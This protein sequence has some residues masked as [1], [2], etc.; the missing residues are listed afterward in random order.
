MRTH[1]LLRF[2]VVFLL[3][4]AC[5]AAQE[6]PTPEK[7]LGFRVGTDKKLASW[8]QVVEYMRM[9]AKASDR[10]RVTDL[11]KSTMGNPFILLTIS[12][13]KNLARMAEIQAD[14][15]KLAYPYLLDEKSAEAIFAKNPVVVLVTMSIHSSE[16]GSTQ[17]SLELVHRLATEHSPYIDNLLDNVVFLLAPSVN[18]DGQVMVIDWYNKNAGTEFEGSSMPWLYHTYVPRPGGRGYE[19]AGVRVAR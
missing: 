2:T 18:P 4:A 16:L 11:D 1:R 13:P 7:Y 5:A 8:P 12:S 3:L 19:G 10:V 9:A 6:L 14:Q 15:R 17:M